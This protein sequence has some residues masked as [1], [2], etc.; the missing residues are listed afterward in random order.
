MKFHMK[1]VDNLLQEYFD[2]ENSN[3]EKVIEELKK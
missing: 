2:F 1:M 3:L